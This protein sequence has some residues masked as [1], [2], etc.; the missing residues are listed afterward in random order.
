MQGIEMPYSLSYRYGPPVVCV[1]VLCCVAVAFCVYLRTLL[2][3]EVEDQNSAHKWSGP[4][5]VI[6]GL[7]VVPGGH[8]G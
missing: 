7:L 8:R 1:Y 3:V 2:E 4:V 6:T 5:T